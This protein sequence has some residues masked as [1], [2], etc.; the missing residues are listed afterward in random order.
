MHI[1]F[2]F[3]GH[4]VPLGIGGLRF[5]VIWKEQ[6]SLFVSYR[7]SSESIK[8]SHCPTLQGT[9]SFFFFFAGFE[10]EKRKLSLLCTVPVTIM[11]VV[12]ITTV[13][14]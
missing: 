14:N 4:R 6:K 1:L 10:N 5:L 13:S 2:W 12:E 8:L 7:R 11:L 9:R 3:A